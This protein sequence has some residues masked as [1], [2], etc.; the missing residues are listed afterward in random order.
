[1]VVGLPDA[2]DDIPNEGPVMAL[3][4]V[5]T[6]PLEIMAKCAVQI[7]GHRKALLPVVFA[8]LLSAFLEVFG[9]L[10]HHRVSVAERQ[11]SKRGQSRVQV[12]SVTVVNV[13]ADIQED[14]ILRIKTRNHVDGN[15]VETTFAFLTISNSAGGI[16][17]AIARIQNHSFFTPK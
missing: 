6:T 17:P 15:K 8:V 3:V 2:A 10:Q 11:R 13:L 9:H 4:V 5:L 1:M 12:L 14:L 16:F 7:I